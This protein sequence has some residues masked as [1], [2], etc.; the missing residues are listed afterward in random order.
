MKTENRENLSKDF[1]VRDDRID[2]EETVLIKKKLLIFCFQRDEFHCW[3]SL[4]P[5]WLLPIGSA[6]YVEL[7]N[8]KY[9]C[10]MLIFTFQLS[11]G[12]GEYHIG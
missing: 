1:S 2:A 9:I 8:V 7:E 10:L 3:V 11:D 4:L 6:D 12:F 5:S